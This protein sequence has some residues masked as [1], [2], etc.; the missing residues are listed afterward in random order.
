MATGKKAVRVH[1]EAKAELDEVMKKLGEAI[2]ERRAVGILICEPV[3]G[4]MFVEAAGVN[5]VHLSYEDANEVMH[6]LE[7]STCGALVLAQQIADVG[8]A[9]LDAQQRERPIV[10]TF[11][12][13]RKSPKIKLSK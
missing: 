10:K 9:Q 6:R 7:L 2:S 1:P 12:K 11:I 8:E 3:E 5:T 4:K 13:N